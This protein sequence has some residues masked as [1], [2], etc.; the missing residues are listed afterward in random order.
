[1]RGRRGDVGVFLDPLADDSMARLL[2][3]DRD[4]S[5]PAVKISLGGYRRSMIQWLIDTSR[6][7]L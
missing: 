2:E 1:M 6:F 4:A 7:P 3:I 5:F